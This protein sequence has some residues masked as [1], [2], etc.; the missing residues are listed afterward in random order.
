MIAA[1][2][3]IVRGTKGVKIEFCLAL[4]EIAVRGSV[5]RVLYPPCGG[6]DH[7]SWMPVT[8]HLQQP[9]RATTRK[10]VICR[11]YLV[12]LPTGLPCHCRYRQRGALLPHRFTLTLAGGLFSVALSLE[13]PPPDVIPR[14]VSVEPRLSSPTGK[15]GRRGHPTL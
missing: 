9:T 4:C 14:R 13:S 11:P 7:S 2:K 1:L 3:N 8:R 15:T 12:L 6:G 5:S 10:P